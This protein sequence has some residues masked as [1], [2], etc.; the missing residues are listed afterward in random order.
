MDKEVQ[1]GLLRDVKDFLNED[2]QKWYADRG[3]PYLLPR[4]TSGKLLPE[5]ESVKTEAIHHFADC[6]FNSPKLDQ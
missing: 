5:H 2:T 3:I 4:A 6:L 1:G